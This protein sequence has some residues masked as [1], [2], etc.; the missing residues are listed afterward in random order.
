MKL[1]HTVL[2]INS[3]HRHKAQIFQLGTWRSLS[4]PSP[5]AFAAKRCF[6]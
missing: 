6:S 1:A 5:A 3:R 4:N 2:N